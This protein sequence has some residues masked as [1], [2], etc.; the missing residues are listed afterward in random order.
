MDAQ[1]S[2]LLLVSSWHPA[3]ILDPVQ[4]RLLTNRR[5]EYFFS[6]SSHF[7]DC[8]MYILHIHIHIHVHVHIHIHFLCACGVCHGVFFY[9]YIYV[10]LY[11]YTMYLYNMNIHSSCVF[12]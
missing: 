2:T 7:V 10:F 3:N 1:S 9:I 5:G 8:D 6:R 11:I 4:L 12:A